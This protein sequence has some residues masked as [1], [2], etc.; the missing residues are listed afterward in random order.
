MK[1]TFVERQWAHHALAAETHDTIVHLRTAIEAFE[2]REPG[3][4]FMRK[5]LLDGLHVSTRGGRRALAAVVAATSAF[6]PRPAPLD[7]VSRFVAELCE[8]DMAA[9]ATGQGD[10]SERTVKLFE[11]FQQWRGPE[12]A[13]NMTLTAF[14]RKLGK[15]GFPVRKRQSGRFKVRVGIRLRA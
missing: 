11:R 10:F 9:A 13:N 8:T 3:D 6:L 4:A 15:M 5:W 2:A 1:S 14:G 12:R 7:P